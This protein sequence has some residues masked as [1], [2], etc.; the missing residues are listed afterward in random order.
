MQTATEL[1]PKTSER[2]SALPF[3]GA[4]LFLSSF[5]LFQV[6]LIF[7]KLILPWFGGAAAVWI[8]CLM[9]FLLAYLLGNLYA[10]WLAGKNS[11]LQSRVHIALLALSLLLLPILPRASWK[12]VSGDNPMLYILGVL[13][14]TIGLPFVIL[15]AT[16]PLLQAW[17]VRDREGGGRPY[18]FY[19][20]SNAASFLA[21]LSY[22]LWVEPYFTTSHQ[23]IGWS[24]AYAVFAVCCAGIAFGE[25]RKFNSGAAP[26]DHFLAGA[27][28][29]APAGARPAWTLQLLWVALA[30]DATA[31]L[32]AVTNHLLQN[33]AAVPMLWILPLALYL[34]SLILCFEGHGWYRRFLFLRLLAVAVGGMTYALLPDFANA[35]PKLQVPL[36]CI[37]LFVCCMVCH[38]EL[39]KLKPNPEYLTSFYV[40]VSAGGALGGIFVGL[41]AP[42]I[43][44][45]FRELPIAI[46][47]CTVLYLIVL[48]RDP[49][50]T[51]YGRWRLAALVLGG[52]LTAVLVF[53]LY[54][55]TARHDD[56]VRFMARNFYGV[57]R[58][59]DLPATD[60]LPFRREL[61]NG[62]IVHGLEILDA[63][64]LTQPTTYYAPQT[65]AGIALLSAENRGALNIGAVGL[66]AGTLAGYG[67]AGDHYVFYEINPLDIRIAQ[68]LF[69]F[70]RES[71]AKIEI[72][73]GDARLS[74]EREP[75]QNFDVLLVDAFSGDAIPI[76]LL[77]REAFQLYL[78][79]LKPD[80]VLAIHVSNRFLDL[81]PVV[82]AAGR[83]L[84]LSTATV[85]NT[86]DQ[87]NLVFTSTWILLA[88]TQGDLP[89]QSPT[90]AYIKVP[91]RILPP[92]TDDYSNL[93]KILK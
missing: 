80:G 33:V 52:A 15:S 87:P 45:A 69:S 57:L 54:Q 88:R 89:A 37:S 36:F 42:L 22:P 25:Q 59:R 34:L 41:I 55:L 9:F 40:M 90:P 17:Y 35:S 61:V 91:P 49:T 79:H 75:A 1:R 19:A 38:G 16:S 66:G 70:L 43:F 93:L 78:R 85:V 31:L 67:R 58:V 86:L 68:T 84:D 11:R 5:L 71:K 73:P 50:T 82:E 60:V 56:G 62:T 6:E 4:T 77:T 47:S 64:R 53:Y 24:L 30:A 48:C 20:L 13:A 83:S 51:L 7:T 12:P 46:G 23:A 27:S 14:T 21:L 76:H 18:R 32:L 26:R 44:S 39:E 3:W 28:T 63:G 81:T 92:W 29:A 72:V 65:G 74:L 10:Y 8:T 2:Y